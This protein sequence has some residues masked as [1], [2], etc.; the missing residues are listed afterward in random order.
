MT[1]AT[2]TK[3]GKAADAG[4]Q[5]VTG[6]QPFVFGSEAAP[7]STALPALDRMNEKLSRRLRA[8]FEGMSRSKVKL[9][10]RAT[11][12]MRYEDWQQDQPD[13]LSLSIFSFLSPTTVAMVALDAAL[14][15]RMVDARYGGSGAAARP[16]NHEFTPTEENCA[17]RLVEALAEA[18]NDNWNEVVPVNFQLKSRETNQAFANVARRDEQVAVVSFDIEIASVAARPVQIIYPLVTLRQVERELALGTKEET[19]DTDFLWRARLRH[20]LGHVRVNA[21]T[22]LARP[23][24]K[25]RDVLNLRPGDIIP[26]NIP[27]H[28]PLL[29]GNR[30]LALG[31]VGDRDGAA[32]IRIERINK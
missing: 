16:G 5:S 21:R 27:P 26:V 3:G 18:L 24:M 22:V 13:Y 29:V 15:M 11:A 6:A 20:A 2:K 10:P 32:A 12:T 23:E 14:I 4:S 25:M 19:A 7:V 30:E 17:T 28:V 8:I 1:V 31:I 9:T